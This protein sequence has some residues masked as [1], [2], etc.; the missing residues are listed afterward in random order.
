MQFGTPFEKFD[1]FWTTTFYSIKSRQNKKWQAFVELHHF[2]NYFFFN[3]NQLPAAKKGLKKQASL[4]TFGP[5]YFVKMW[6]IPKSISLLYENLATSHS[7]CLK[8]VSL[9]HSK[10]RSFHH[11]CWNFSIFPFSVRKI[12]MISLF[13]NHLRWIWMV[14]YPGWPKSVS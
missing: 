3:F 6:Y 7:A 13:F 11:Q 4:Q 9:K 2:F 5:S 1:G 10:I 12:D 8:A 14:P